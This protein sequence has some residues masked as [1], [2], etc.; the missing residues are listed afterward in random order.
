M[1]IGFAGMGK[2]GAAMAARLAEQGQPPT[3]WNRTRA[4]AEATGLAVAD[5]PRALAEGA[6]LILTSLFDDDAVHA[7]F[8][9]T[10]GLLA[11]DLTG[12]LVVEMSTLR[13]HT[14]IALAE[15]VAARGGAA[16]E[17][18]VGGTTGPAR[19]GTLLGMAGGE[20]A[21]V[22]RA[23]PV[24]DLLCRRVEHVGGH[25]AAAAL[26][27]AINLP[28]LVFWQSFGEANALVRHL[29]LDPA[30]L[31]EFFA[32]TSGAPT[33]LRNR[34]K[35]IAATLAGSDPDAVTFDIDSIRKDLA[36]MVAEAAGRGVPLPAASAALASFDQAS[37]AGWGGR[38]CTWLP[39][40]W[41]A[42]AG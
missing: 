19:A 4:R 26:K 22:A 31:V 37:Q 29:G 38:D 2:M 16:L 34:G 6:D 27:L 41:A 15:A 9:E 25:G 30:W 28:L 32:D 14:Q 23:G 7:V 11:A 10:D 40:F 33:V 5:T 17:C 8:H 18:P 20:A 42:K 12:K 35:A 24:L 13:P 3:V 1:R 21:D 36:T 39:A